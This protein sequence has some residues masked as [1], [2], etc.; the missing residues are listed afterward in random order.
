MTP[1][2]IANRKRCVMSHKACR[3]SGFTLIELLVVIG[4]IAVIAAMG[5][6]AVQKIRETAQ[7]V[8][9]ANNLHQIG[10]A[11]TLHYTTHRVLPGNGGWDNTQWIK[12][13]NGKPTYV[14]TKDYV[15]GMWYWGVGDPTKSPQQQSGSWA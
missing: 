10:I 3:R 14:Y 2:S 6:V 9:C 7:R 1:D 4:I 15:S 13:V 11:A 8:S 5:I 12:D